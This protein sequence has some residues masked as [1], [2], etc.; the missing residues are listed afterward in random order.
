MFRASISLMTIV[1]L[2]A[3]SLVN[4]YQTSWAF[5]IIEPKEFTVHQSGDQISVSLD[6]EGLPG[7]TKVNYYWYS[8]FDDM[9]RE[10]V[11]EKLALVATAKNSPPFGGQIL[12]P[13]EMIGT[14]RLLAVAEQG[15]RQSQHESLA[16]FDE[17]LIQVEPDAELL[18]IDFQTDKPLKFG[19]A[20]GTRVYDQ[21]DFLGK[22][23]E[24][25]VIG[26]F[27]DGISR[28]LRAQSTGT[29]YQS[30]NDNI[31]SVNPNG[32]LR[33]MGN[34]ETTLTVKNRHQEATLD[35]LVEVNDEPNHPPVSDPGIT[36]TVFSG[37]RV[38]LNGLRS[39]DPDGGSLQYHWE[40]V[41]GSKVPLLDPY[42]AQ[43]KFLAP[44]VVEERLFRFTLRVTDIQGADSLPAFVDVIITP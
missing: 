20:S 15:G 7:V 40:Q 35:I 6:L 28:S 37:T 9:L 34:G 39:Y 31:I 19:R 24:L 10:F 33:L 32:V 21:V 5:S 42:S 11:E 1:F 16:I 44:F 26:R 3:L 23:F 22:T 18:E 14:Y 30:A 12:I 29:T 17:I 38:T 2:T 41:R 8:E 25:P 13:K 4:G 43:A 36:Q 27:S